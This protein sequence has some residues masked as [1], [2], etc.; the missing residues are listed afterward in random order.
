MSNFKIESIDTSGDNIIEAVPYT[1][2]DGDGIDIEYDDNSVLYSNAEFDENGDIITPPA[3]NVSR[4][5]V[6]DLST[7]HLYADILR[8]RDILDIKQEDVLNLENKVFI[9][10]PDCENSNI[11]EDLLPML[12]EDLSYVYSTKSTD[13]YSDEFKE[14]IININ[15]SKYLIYFIT[16][17]SRNIRAI[18]QAIQNSHKHPGRVILCMI[19]TYN[20]MKFKDEYL[21]DY[22]EVGQ[23]I[24]VNGGKFFMSLEDLA[25]FIN[26]N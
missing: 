21:D 9:E 20:G 26:N 11:M 23:T 14:D 24:V 5:V 1:V 15:K 22:C 3:E 7:I 6:V 10:T 17:S 19:K 2:T 18:Q 8:A 4:E 13:V 25:N 16:P 12:N